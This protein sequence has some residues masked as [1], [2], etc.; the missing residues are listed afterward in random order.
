MLSVALALSACGGEPVVRPA[1][2]YPGP[3]KEISPEVQRTMIQNAKQF[4]DCGYAFMRAS[5]KPGSEFLV[6]CTSG[7]F[8]PGM[9]GK[10]NPNRKWD[11]Y[12]VFSASG[13][14]MG[15]NQIFGD[16]PPPDDK[17]WLFKKLN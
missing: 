7:E 12:L 17:M 11:A 5:V 15:P 8:A 2:R 13:K 1:E 4:H 16:I 10:T 3:W 9:E 14:I 6:Y